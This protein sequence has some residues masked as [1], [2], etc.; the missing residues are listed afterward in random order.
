MPQIELSAGVIDYEDSGGDGPVLVLLGG[1]LM[2]AR[3]WDPLVERLRGEHRFVVPTLPLGAH[4]RPMRPDAD[5][6]LD[7]YGRMVAELLERLDLRDVTLVQNDHAAGL[8]LAGKRPERV[9]RLVV[10][11]CEAF[12]NYPGTRGQERAPAWFHPRRA[13]P[14]RAVHAPGRAAPLP[15]RLRRARQAGRCPTSSLTPGCVRC[16][17]SAV[18]GATCAAT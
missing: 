14:R 4:R 18:C 7:G 6:S 17:R 11:P 12:E 1:L 3:V 5:L 8:V 15:D 9:A 10:T 13:V 16:R 2:D